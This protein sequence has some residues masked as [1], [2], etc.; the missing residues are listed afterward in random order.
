MQTSEGKWLLE[1]TRTKTPSPFESKERDR[2]QVKSVETKS[3]RSL[4]SFDAPQAIASDQISRNE[5]QSITR[6][7]RRSISNSERSP[8]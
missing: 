5:K 3:T 7:L 4:A 2:R 1:Q 8:Q 6:L